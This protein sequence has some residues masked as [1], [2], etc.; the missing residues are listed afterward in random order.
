M[1][2]TT[3]KEL[4][5]LCAL[6]K[7]EKFIAVDTEFIRE[8]TY[9]S[10][11]CLIQIATPSLATCID[12]LSQDMD[13]K[14]LFKIM[15]NKK[16]I[17]VF[18]SGFPD[19]E[20]FHDL[21]GKVPRNVFDTQIASMVYGLGESVSYQEMVRKI[22]RVKLDKS[23]RLTDWSARPLSKEQI[24]Y[25]LC[26]VTYLV[27]AY[28]KLSALLQ[29]DGR[30]SWIAEEMQSLCDEKKYLNEPSE[31]WKK[32]KTT[33]ENT[34][35]L[36]VLR[37]VAAAREEY[38]QS[39]NRPRRFVLKDEVLLSLASSCPRN[40]EELKSTRGIP[41][42]IEKSSLSE[43][44]INAV[45]KGLKS[46]KKP[47]LPEKKSAGHQKP[48][49]DILR[50]LLSSVAENSGVAPSLIASH[51]DLIDMA[52]NHLKL[53]GWRYELFGKVSDDFLSG[54]TAIR[55]KSGKIVIE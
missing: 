34:Q 23:C 7:K 54:K 29:K 24:K 53:K 33:S 30:D 2:I 16:I 32:I 22:C 13:L 6:L 40:I 44:L 17:K 48:V 51:D 50:L 38:A 46:R 19:I 31:Q 47:T 52:Q 45:K 12:P 10:T 43:M 5:E 14:P 8:R 18:H 41:G 1:M 11:L 55:Y 9:Y 3:K 20:I 42:G 36:N 37:E 4:K 39:H 49:V 26:D 15:S 35:F 27:K 28:Q 25:A 21:T